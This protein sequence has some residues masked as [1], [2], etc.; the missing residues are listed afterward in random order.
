MNAVRESIDRMLDDLPPAAADR[1]IRQFTQLLEGVSS[2]ENDGASSEEIRA[3]IARTQ[4]G[5]IAEED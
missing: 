5:W 1:L 4:K 3:M 2:M